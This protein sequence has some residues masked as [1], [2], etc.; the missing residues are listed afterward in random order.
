MSWVLFLYVIVFFAL[1]F[2]NK[3]ISKTWFDA[4]FYV[5]GPYVTI[6]LMNNI[7]FTRIG[8]VDV[9]DKS[10][11]IYLMTTIV[12]F[13]GKIFGDLLAD[14]YIFT[15]TGH[16]IVKKNSVVSIKLIRTIHIGA[17][18]CIFVDLFIRIE[19]FGLKNISMGMEEYSTYTL[20]SHLL[21]TI[22]PF[23]VIL[24]ENWIKEHKIIDAILALLSFFVTL[25]TFVKYNVII[26][27]LII[28]IYLLMKWPKL[29]LKIV[30]IVVGAIVSAF[31]LNYLINFMAN[32]NQITS[33]FLFY[34]LWGYISG[35]IVNLEKGTIYF[36]GNSNISL[37]KWFLSMFMATPNMFINK[38][39]LPVYS[40]SFERLVP[41]FD[42]GMSSSNVIN[43]AGTVYI[44]SNLIEYILFVLGWGFINE[45]IYKKSLKTNNI[46]FR[47]VA[48]T[49][50]GFNLLSFF[51]CFFVLSAPWEQMIQT[52]VIFGIL[53][54]INKNKNV[55]MYLKI[56][57]KSIV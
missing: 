26:I 21:L 17:L 49:F 33:S 25:M 43:I 54:K 37:G 8:F 12:F 13:V 14:K 48:S 28:F 29:F 5:M 45:F 2:L 27:F 56:Q 23:T 50:L 41:N 31:V 19:Q 51:G 44:Q 57:H 9:S 40:Y 53:S 3:K 47:L 30:P 42:L 18:V 35:G 24:I 39:G 55:N 38:M 6:V 16:Q 46:G 7:I 11:V 36:E 32:G 22:V 1:Y 10:I 4:F 15:L 20:A 34:H 52:I